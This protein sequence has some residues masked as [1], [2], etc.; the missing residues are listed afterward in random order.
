ME[1]MNSLYAAMADV[2]REEAFLR[3]LAR[4]ALSVSRLHET[5]KRLMR[6]F[7]IRA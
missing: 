7:R 1:Q 5:R 2:F 4:P 3:K 6:L